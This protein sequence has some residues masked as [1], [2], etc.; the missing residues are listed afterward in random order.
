MRYLTCMV[1]AVGLCFATPV[2]APVQA[3][4]RLLVK[5]TG[6][7]EADPS[8]TYTLRSE[9]GPWMVMVANFQQWG[10][11]TEE[12]MGST[13]MEAAQ[14]LV[15]EL[16]KLKIPA[17]VYQVKG[18]NESV[19]SQDALG[20]DQR[21]KN[22]RVLDSVCVLAGN[23]PTID[24]DKAQQTLKFIKQYH[25]KSFAE[26]VVYGKSPGRPGP[27]SR[28]FLTPNPLL[29]N[30]E[31]ESAKQAA[32]PLL[33]SLNNNER[34]SLY[35]NKGKYTLVIAKFSG[36]SVN[37]VNES[38]EKAESY[39]TTGGND[40]DQAASSARNLVLALRRREP[41]TKFDHPDFAEFAAYCR[42]DAYIWHDYTSSV[43]TVGSFESPTDPEVKKYTELFGPKV[44]LTESSR[45]AYTFRYIPVPQ[46]EGGFNY[47]PFDPSPQ[48]M[49]V[50]H[51]KK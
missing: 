22:M 43:V 26:G 39:F 36:K 16:R 50:P 42:L 15:M 8:K 24:H 7:I 20:R 37:V 28:A 19:K 51:A 48:M 11:N 30:A 29:T 40:L 45:P 25:P 5:M 47:I 35:E 14:A 34:F 13:P 32:D 44:T 4:N 1:I 18:K 23:Y 46:S 31:I 38:K 3:Q 6:K 49:V 41:L 27:L 33:V 21:M 17:Y 2:V 12:K 10:S 9:H